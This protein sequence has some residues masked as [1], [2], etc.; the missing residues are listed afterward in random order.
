MKT[1]EDARRGPAAVLI[2]ALGDPVQRRW[3]IEESGLKIERRKGGWVCTYSQGFN[4][5]SQVTFDKQGA[6][7]GID[8]RAPPVG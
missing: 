6:L 2:L 8:L 7:T 3:K 5:L 1:K 4:Y